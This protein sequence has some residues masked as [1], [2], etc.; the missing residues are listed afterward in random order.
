MNSLTKFPSFTIAL[1]TIALMVSAPAEAASLTGD[2]IFRID[3]TAT[4][5]SGAVQTLSGTANKDFT[6]YTLNIS[7]G[8]TYYPSGPM[9]PTLFAGFTDTGNVKSGLTGSRNSIYNYLHLFTA[10]SLE[11][12]LMN[13]QVGD[14]KPLNFLVT[15]SRDIMNFGGPA[16]DTLAVNFDTAGYGTGTI[17]MIASEPIPEPGE[18]L[19]MAVTGAMLGGLFLKRRKFAKV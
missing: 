14:I 3:G 11:S 17:S 5:K 7:G 13:I 12:D 4:A 19:G 2:Q 8:G 18:W 10:T 6:K 1:A 15:G 16:Y 9:Q